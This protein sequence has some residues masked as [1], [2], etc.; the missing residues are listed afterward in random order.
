M[1]RSENIAWPGDTASG[2]DQNQRNSSLAIARLHSRARLSACPRIIRYRKGTQ[3]RLATTRDGTRSLKA[4][5][6]SSIAANFSPRHLDLNLIFVLKFGLIHT[7]CSA[8]PWAPT[9]LRIYRGAATPLRR[10][11]SIW[12]IFFQRQPNTSPPFQRRPPC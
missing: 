2:S 4:F 5:H 12:K 7:A 1:L 3:P 8:S 10:H 11:R 9:T 6:F